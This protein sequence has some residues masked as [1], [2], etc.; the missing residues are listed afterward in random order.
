MESSHGN[1]PTVVTESK[2]YCKLVEIQVLL[3][4]LDNIFLL[5]VLQFPSAERLFT[6][7]S[8]FFLVSYFSG[9]LL[10]PVKI[11]VSLHGSHEQCHVAGQFSP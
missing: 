2:H 10:L 9:Q 8:P 4:T 3:V 5:S 1:A 7:M 11:A 6:C